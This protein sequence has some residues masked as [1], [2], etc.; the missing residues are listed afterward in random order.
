M[1]RLAV[2]ASGRGSNAAA[3]FAA[4]RDGLLDARAV[5]LLCDRMGA[6]VMGVAEES[7]VPVRL[8][9][10]VDFPTRAAWDEAIRDA[11][12]GTRADLVALA[13]FSAILGPACLEAFAERIVN[14]HPSLLPDFAGRAAPGPQEAAL[15]AGV[16]VSGCT[17]H[18][19][20]REVDAGPILAQATVPV[21]PGDTVA[22]LSARI[23]AEEHRLY[24]AVLQALAQGRLSMEAG[25]VVA[26]TGRLD[27]QP[28]IST[29][30]S[31]ST[32]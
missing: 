22:S 25:Q 30:A 27:D 14:I 5:L 7:G 21:H 17:V 24:P 3:I 2:L 12:I 16:T 11:L 8:V 9:V 4:I 26:E 19:V 18:L 15:R 31:P 6:P 1:I 32:R 23:L 29:Q 28:R 20:T 10:R 13:G